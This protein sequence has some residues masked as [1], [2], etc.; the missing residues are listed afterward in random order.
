MAASF[1]P[2]PGPQTRFLSSAADIVIYG[3]G[4]GGGKSYG[5]LLECLRHIAV[6]G[7]RAVVFRRTSPEITNP[8]GLWDES[9]GLY[10]LIGG[11]A[12][13]LRWSWPRFGSRVQFAHLQYEKDLLSW[14]G[15]QVPLICFDE[16][17]TFTRRQFFYLL[18]R[19]R[20]GTGIKPYIR[21]TCNPDADSWVAEFIAW[22]IDQASG[23][24]IPERDGVVRWFVRGGSDEVIW[25]DRP[26]DLVKHMPNPK[27]LPPGVSLDAFKPKS[28]TFIRSR[29]Y[30]NLAL[31][32]KDP[33]YLAN[34]LALDLVERG[35]LLDGNWKI[36]A[37]AGLYFQ[38]KWLLNK[39][40]QLGELPPDLK[41]IRG[42]DLAATPKT[43]TNDPDFTAG[44]KLGFSQERG[45]LVMMGH[46]RGQLDQFGVDGLIRQTAESDGK[47]VEVCL[48]QDPGAAGK[49]M[50]T[51]Y[52]KLLNGFNVRWSPESGGDT[53]R[54]AAK[55][56][57]KIKRFGP[58]TSQAK[59]GNI[60]YLAGDWNDTLFTQLEAFPDAAHDDDADAVSRA[61]WGF[62]SGDTGFLDFLRQQAAASAA[63]AQPLPEPGTVLV[64]NSPW[65]G[66]VEPQG[67]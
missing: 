21:A 36:K 41:K 19:N 57:A 9:L 65:Q 15:A 25:G 30:D 59:A 11:F 34:L 16:L 23:L 7:F 64:S 3:G 63:A 47:D 32:Q 12:T 26:E 14:H 22:W 62:Q 43:E 44:H 29:V 52:A 54:T 33:G 40:L 38:R 20:S 66:T 18:S 50:I 58:V 4:A 61:Y 28:V 5:L 1:R 55:I 53:A 27:D 48:P 8:G 31:L 56:S 35:R 46:V 10:P 37:A 51:H 24:P 49:G 17:T 2:Q 13:K 6:R 42:W 45:M 60:F 67:D 39:V